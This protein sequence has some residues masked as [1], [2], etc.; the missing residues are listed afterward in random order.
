MRKSLLGGGGG[1]GGVQPLGVWQMF[2]K[3]RDAVEDPLQGCREMQSKLIGIGIVK[4]CN[5]NSC[6]RKLCITIPQERYVINSDKSV[7]PT[8]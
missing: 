8:L 3:Y 6:L 4:I 2:C 7:N 1:G 5:A